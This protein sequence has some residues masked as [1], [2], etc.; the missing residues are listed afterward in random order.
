MNNLSE[1]KSSANYE[2]FLKNSVNKSESAKAILEKIKNGYNPTEADIFELM[3]TDQERI[4]EYRAFHDIRDKVSS[5]E[6]ISKEDLE[7]LI[8]ELDLDG[9]LSPE[10]VDRITLSEKT[11]NK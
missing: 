10:L 9:K 4:D 3:N 8:S 1:I 2:F 7:L 6:K 5:N 11:N